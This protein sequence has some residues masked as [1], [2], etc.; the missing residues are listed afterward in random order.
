MR[1]LQIRFAALFLCLP[2]IFVIF[3][4]L[5]L[6]CALLLGLW[7]ATKQTYSFSEAGLQSL[8]DTWQ[9]IITGDLVK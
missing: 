4:C 7:E 5:A 8:R 2:A 6:P 9:M 3:V 1:A